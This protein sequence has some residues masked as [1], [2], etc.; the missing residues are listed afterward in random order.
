MIHEAFKDK[1]FVREFELTYLVIEPVKEFKWFMLVS[2]VNASNILDLDSEQRSKLY[3]DIELVAEFVKNYYSP[4]RIN[5]A[6]LGNITNHLH[7]HIIAR[8]SNDACWPKAVFGFKST[9]TGSLFFKTDIDAFN[10]YT[11]NL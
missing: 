6:M 5:I 8:F 10:V 1:I 7:V 9:P 11:N 2:K 4:D 3:K